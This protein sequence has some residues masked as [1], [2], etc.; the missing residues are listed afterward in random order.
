MKANQ[1]HTVRAP[2]PAAMPAKGFERRLA[3]GDS[4]LSES[5][6]ADL[7][8]RHWLQRA[9]TAGSATSSAEG[10][11][12]G[13]L[14]SVSAVIRSP[15]H[16][17]ETAAR[18]G[19]E[20]VF[21]RDFSRVRVH[22]DAAAADSAHAV[23][24]SAYTVGNHIAF[25]PGQ[26]AP[27]TAAGKRLLAH[28]LTHVVQ[29]SAATV[30]SADVERGLTFSEPADASE[31]IAER[32][33]D[34]QMD[35]R[36]V[37]P[38]NATA[39]ARLPQQKGAKPK[40]A[41][42]KAPAERQLSADEAW[43]FAENR[44]VTELE[45]RYEELVR[46]A[47]FE[48]KSQISD[49]FQ[50]YSDD[51]SADATFSTILGV[52]ASGA[53]NVPNDP[54]SIQQVP[55]GSPAGTK[56]GPI[57][58]TF[59]VSGGIAG[60]ISGSVSPLVSMILDTSKVGEVRDNL[61]TKVEEFLVTGLTTSSS[62]F[63]AFETQARSELRVYFLSGWNDKDQPHTPAGADTLI[64]ATAQH[65]RESYGATSRLGAQIKE[66]VAGYVKKQL[67]L[68]QPQLD[69]LERKHRESRIGAFAVG[70]GLVGGLLGGALGF[71]QGGVG[72]L[73]LG[74]G[75]GLAAGAGVGALAGVIT[76]AKSSSAADVRAK[77]AREDAEKEKQNKKA[78][79]PSATAVA[80]QSQT[81]VA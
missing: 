51:L 22:T 56:G 39:V 19:M 57:P 70:G 16:A 33:S 13:A 75:I 31:Q 76:N 61:N 4:V 32:V 81:E 66:S 50:P 42:T 63:S 77:K 74:A 71:S 47:A 9:A 43:L 26:Y 2:R 54:S 80:T 69:S 5:Q 8:G 38:A 65:A 53:G 14:S 7:A 35:A 60:L 44:L 23:E 20:G 40:P 41:Q 24:A 59:S 27:G 36:A 62:T 12:R 10:V 64:N 79:D 30:S 25:A 21:G 45:T 72:G 49:F 55:K 18:T 28:E 34:G 58:Q 48:T 52:A 37:S 68:I 3:L 78:A 46:A 15:G 6:P 29:Q 17:M 11:G 67:D 73:F 1:Q